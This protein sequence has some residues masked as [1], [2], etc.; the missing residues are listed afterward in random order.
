MC[1]CTLRARPPRLPS[2]M[3]LTLG[4]RASRIALFDGYGFCQI[5]RLVNIGAFCHR[6]VVGEQ[7]N[8]KRVEHRRG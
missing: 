5:A 1:A 7:L 8:G 6:R 4:N 2:K 3:L